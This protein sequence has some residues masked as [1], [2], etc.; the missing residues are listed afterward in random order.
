[1]E[2]RTAEILLAP[3]TPFFATMLILVGLYS[4]LIN[5]ADAR[6]KKQL[7]AKKTAFIGGWIYIIAGV[8]VLLKGLF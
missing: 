5:V 3:L 8:A 2:L 1:M 6:Q 4:L 7:R